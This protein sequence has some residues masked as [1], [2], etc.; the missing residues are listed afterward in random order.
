MPHFNEHKTFFRL[1]Y[2]ASPGGR[3]FVRSNLRDEALEAYLAFKAKEEKVV[4]EGQAM[5]RIRND[6]SSAELVEFIHG[7]TVSTLARW[8]IEGGEKDRGKQMRLLWGF[9][10]GGMGGV[11]VDDR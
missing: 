3:A 9:L 6:M 1:F 8:S 7:V 4:R 11:D 5:G 2:T 10:Y